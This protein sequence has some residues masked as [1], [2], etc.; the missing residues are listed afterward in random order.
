VGASVAVFCQLLWG[1]AA[2][3]RRARLEVQSLTD[4]G[5][6]VPI[7]TQQPVPDRARERWPALVSLD[8]VV[9]EPSRPFALHTSTK[10]LSFIA[11]SARFARSNLRRGVEAA[12]AHSPAGIVGALPFAR[13]RQVPLIYVCHTSPPPR[14][15]QLPARHRL[16]TRVVISTIEGAALR[17]ADLVVCPSPSSRDYYAQLRR[18]PTISVENPIDTERFSPDPSRTRDVDILFVGRLA[19]E[20]GAAV[21][22]RAVARIPRP[23]RTVIIGAGTQRSELERLASLCPGEVSF[24]GV[25]P[26]RELVDWFRRTRIVAVPSFSEAAG[27]VPVEAMASGTPVLASRV[28]GLVDTVVDGRNGWLVS[29]GDD[30]AWAAKLNKLL[31]D[32]ARLRAAGAEGV[33]TAR[34]FDRRAFSERLVA[35]YGLSAHTREA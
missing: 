2:V 12:I 31:T 19:A 11:A 6:Q 27:M 29:A 16:P 15:Q 7:L 23:L 10:L 1:D 4:A 5:F 22:L 35:E 32:D 14:S 24:T 28:S 18:G 25:V 13:V 34:R 33:E 17:F 3:E 26:N 21:L 9:A 20:K 8:P 30:A